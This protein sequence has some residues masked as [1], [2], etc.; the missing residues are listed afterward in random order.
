M[1]SLEEAVR[2]DEQPDGQD[3]GASQ[4][5]K[6]RWIKGLIGDAKERL[7]EHVLEKVREELAER[8]AEKDA[9]QAAKAEQKEAQELAKQGQAQA[10]RDAIQQAIDCVMGP[11]VATGAGEL[12]TGRF[13]EDEFIKRIADQEV[14]EAVSA[15]QREL[16]GTDFGYRI[17]ES[18]VRGQYF[19]TGPDGQRLEGQQ[20]P[21]LMK[22]EA[23]LR[24][25]S[26]LEASAKSAALAAVERS[27]RNRDELSR[28]LFEKARLNLAET[29]DIKDIEK[30]IKSD[31]E[32]RN[33]SAQVE[34]LQEDLAEIAEYV[35][36][37]MLSAKEFKLRR[38]SGTLG[39]LD[40]VA[41]KAGVGAGATSMAASMHSVGW[42]FVTNHGLRTGAGL[43][44][45]PTVAH[46]AVAAVA[47]A[48]FIGSKLVQR[49]AVDKAREEGRVGG[50]LERRKVNK[51]LEER[52]K[53]TESTRIQLEGELKG[54]LL[55]LEVR[56]NQIAREYRVQHYRPS[57]DA[58]EALRKRANK[59]GCDLTVA[60]VREA[61]QGLYTRRVTDG[62]Q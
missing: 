44:F 12:V 24:A 17:E 59:Q 5:A 23:A 2:L 60:E 21:G 40:N 55:Q 30:A 16:E 6:R 25:V 56:G 36:N 31:D 53:E 54:A 37:E 49:A 45:H 46:P 50:L 32:I 13:F 8:A 29:G 15:R 51:A 34:S 14:T 57:N 48:W 27:V 43:V 58:I 20:D 7:D 47:G 35:G 62:W 18:A 9:E 38:K 61:L 3:Q 10:R 39:R 11:R 41:G 4:P 28:G 52:V 42:V 19:V 22:R 26:A 33:L 1:G